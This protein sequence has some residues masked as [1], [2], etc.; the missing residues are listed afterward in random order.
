MEE[1]FCKALARGKA[2]RARVSRQTVYI[3]ADALNNRQ[4]DLQSLSS[5]VGSLSGIVPGLMTPVTEEHPVPEKVTWAEAARVSI[6]FKDGKLW[7]LIEPDVWIGP[8]RARRFAVDFL[9]KRRGGRFNREFNDL[10]DAW[11]H[12]VLGTPERN[13][14]VA[15]MAFDDGTGAENPSFRI[16]SRTAFARRH[17][18]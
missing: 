11:V 5:L 10:L 15:L 13:A 2:L 14:E 17:L 4:E 1:V 12:V 3:V 7:L 6:D 18:G 8:P 9:D 16:S